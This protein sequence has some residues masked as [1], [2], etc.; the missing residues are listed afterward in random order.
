VV[1]H[2]GAV[3]DTTYA[4]Y[5]FPIR[6]ETSRVAMSKQS[7]TLQARVCTGEGRNAGRL[8]GSSSGS[9]WIKS[10]MNSAQG[11]K[12]YSWRGSDGVVMRRGVG[13]QEGGGSL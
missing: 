10:A 1:T 11:L 13:E 12:S 5:P 9:Y 2:L 3:P 6:K 4:S 7:P 8:S